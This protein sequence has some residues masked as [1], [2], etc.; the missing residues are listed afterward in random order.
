MPLPEARSFVNAE[1]NG[2]KIKP[3]NRIPLIYK[4]L[5]A[6]PLLIQ[7][8]PIMKP[9]ITVS[10][11]AFKSNSLIPSRYT[12]D[13]ENIS[14]QLSWSKGPEGTRS[15]ALIC[16]DP[17]APSK[18]WV[19]WIIY[20]IPAAIHEIPEKAA[21]IQGAKYGKTDSGKTVYGGPCPP[22]GTHHYHF[23]VYALDSE[24]NLPA[25]ASKQELESAMKAHILAQGELVGLYARKR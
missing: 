16:D 5:V 8:T 13:G 1:C 9:E 4:L 10:S 7:S 23:K 15:Y 11:N 22:S 14:P 2:V 20:N 18:V 21:V 3:M 24:L 25:G 6:I 17:D 19:H 12:C